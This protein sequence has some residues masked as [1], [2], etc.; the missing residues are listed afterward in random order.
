MKRN[1]ETLTLMFLLTMGATFVIIGLTNWHDLGGLHVPGLAYMLWSL[2]YT[3]LWAHAK[4]IIA[5]LLIIGATLAILGYYLAR[6]IHMIPQPPNPYVEPPILVMETGIGVFGG[7][8]INLIAA[9]VKR[10]TQK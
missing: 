1:T 9:A 7:G 3:R 2:S 6:T 10:G 8:I 4:Y 5:T